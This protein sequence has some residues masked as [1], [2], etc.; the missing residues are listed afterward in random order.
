MGP[1]PGYVFGGA[2]ERL[3][4][5]I[6]DGLLIYLIA[7]VGF[8]LGTIL[9]VIFSPLGLIVF[10]ATP[11]VCLAS[12]HGSGTRRAR[13]RASRMFGMQVVRDHDGGPISVGA[14][15][16]RLVGYWI[17]SLVFYSGSSGSHRQAQALLARPHRRHSGDQADL[18]EGG[19]G[20]RDPVP[21]A[22]ILAPERWQS[23][24]L[25]RS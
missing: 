7:V 22:G 17:D 24:R 15:I 5:Y 6:V 16:L 23:G 21:A 8:V 2:G 25:R 9:V 12:S 1:A 18:G 19:P 11:I 10:L 4:A 3:I 13:R 20:R 14:A